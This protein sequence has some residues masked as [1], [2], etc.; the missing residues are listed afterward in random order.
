[1]LVQH[2]IL[3][4]GT[5]L[6]A[7]TGLFDYV[8]AAN[9]VFLHSRRAEF[10]ALLPLT[11]TPIRGLAPATPCFELVPPRVPAALLEQMLTQARAARSPAG[12]PVEILFHLAWTDTWTLT[13]PPQLQTPTS[14]QLLPALDGQPAP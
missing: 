10:R 11:T 4:P 1:M 6:P 8:L 9:G 12:G 14:V 5:V 2:H 7:P 3:Y 13:V